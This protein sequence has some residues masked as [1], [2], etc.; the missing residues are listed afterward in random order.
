MENS[1]ESNMKQTFMKSVFTILIAQVFI[2]ILG[3]IYRFVITNIE[4]FGDQGNG[5]YSAGYQI[6]TLLIAISSMGI[7]GAIS[8]MVSEKI[9]QN[10]YKGAHRIFKVAFILFGIIGT[11]FSLVLF[12]GANFIGNV[13]LDN[14]GVEYTIMCL[15][16][17]IL[18]VCLSAVIRGYFNGMQNMKATARSQTI[19]Q[20]FNCILTIAIVVLL[21][22]NVPEIMAAGSSIATTLATISSFIY[23]MLFYRKRKKEIWKN[24]RENN[25]ETENKKIS[26][27]R[28]VKSIL[29]LSIPISLGSIISA[30]NRNIDSITVIRGLKAS[31]GYT[32]EIANYWYGI[33]SGKVDMLTN[34]PLGFN[35]AFSIALIPAISGALAKKDYKT[36]E[37]RFTFSTLLTILIALPSVVGMVVLADPILNLLF[38]NAPE[39][40]LL[41]QISAIAVIFTAL[42]QTFNGTLQG[43]GKVFVPAI[44][45]V[46]GGIAKLIL[47]IVLIYNP[48]FN[49]YG[50]AISSV[51]C[52]LI[53]CVISF[54][55]LKKNITFKMEVKKYFIK[56]VIANIIMGIIAICSYNIFANMI[57]M[58]IGT[59]IAIGLAI[60]SYAIAIVLLKILDKE[61]FYMLPGGNNLIKIL[62]KIK[63][64]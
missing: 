64:Y 21:T 33:L 63:I 5:F 22:G 18:F 54:S 12:L 39:G 44:A 61:E 4:G 9:A 62:Q 27:K 38:P 23:L 7:P 28:I 55:I 53:A 42:S 45:L 50:A 58:K 10:D 8:K 40:A 15:A 1:K 57:G 49:V 34:L 26:V 20:I 2:K 6:Y 36:I 19:E 35:I 24:I 52:Q 56:P 25:I 31:M 3:F 32:D 30:I 11:T 29:M 14:P 13:I 47:N 60:I 48:T 16:P 59:L 46:F 37:K 41:L 43:L 17:A 51:I